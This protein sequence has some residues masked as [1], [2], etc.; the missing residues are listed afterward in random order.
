MAAGGP[1]T[2]PLLRPRGLVSMTTPTATGRSSCKLSSWRSWGNPQTP[3]Y[4]M[5]EPEGEHGGDRQSI[6]SISKSE[7]ATSSAS[8]SLAD[9]FAGLVF[10]AYHETLVLKTEQSATVIIA[11][12]GVTG[13]AA[14]RT[15][16]LTQTCGCVTG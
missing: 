4:D 3:G 6:W 7:Q 16:E 5:Q 1:G 11:H 12:T 14:L 8:S 10:L 9:L 2:L 13:G 15:G